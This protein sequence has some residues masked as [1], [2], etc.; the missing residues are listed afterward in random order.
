MHFTPGEV[1]QNEIDKL[2][3]QGLPYHDKLVPT[4]DQV[5]SDSMY[6]NAPQHRRAKAKDNAVMR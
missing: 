4:P 2:M 3:A 6:C 5:Q 1:R